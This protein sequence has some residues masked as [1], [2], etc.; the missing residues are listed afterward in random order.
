MNM[1]RN[2][3]RL[4]IPPKFENDEEKTRL[5]G[6][7]NSILLFVIVS[8]IIAV[9]LLAF[10]TDAANRL[11][12]ILFT[13]P[14]IVINVVSYLLLRRGNVPLASSLFLLSTGIGI[15][16][17]YVFSEPQSVAAWL[18]FSLLI[19]F[20]ALLLDFRA[21]IRLVVTIIIL[22][23]IISIAQMRGWITP[24]LIADTNPLS[25]W[26]TSSFIFILTGLGLILSSIRLRQAL[27]TARA[28]QE[29][30]QASNQDLDNLRQAL[31]LR[32]RERSAELEKRAAQLQTV[33]TVARTIAAVQDLELLLPEIARLVSDQFGFYHVGIFLLDDA[34]E[35]AVLRAANSEGGARMLDRHHKLKLD[36]NS[37]VGFATSRGVPRVALDVGADAVYLNNP[38]LPDT[39]SEMALPLRVGGRVIGALDVQSTQTNAFS[40]E[41]IG[42]LATLADQV[43]IAIEN[44]R[45]FGEARK[46]LAESQATFEKYVKQEWSSFARQS[47]QTGFVFDGKQVLPLDGDG[48]RQARTLPQTGS[49][50]WEKTSSTISVPIRLRGQTIGVLDVRPKSGQREWT[51]NEIALLEAAAERAAL[52]L[53]NAR[54]VES[55]QRRAA[56][57]RSISNIAAKIGAVSDIDL[58]LQTTVEELG[59][60]IG[61]TTEVILELEGEVI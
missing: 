11:P 42:V 13:A 16:G 2:F 35:F 31:E 34:N 3:R 28:S 22:T 46:A 51:Q 19:V 23:F 4:L 6:L 48:K 38:D 47:R 14:F 45:L 58:I 40:Q 61:G 37:I 43:A 26:F 36:M 59:R 32:V 24:L 27:D 55:A 49:L 57:E 12:L 25:N 8:T 30:L 20:T 15:I 44:A 52:A 10:S 7:L 53:E 41:D 18:S 50:S 9:P 54:L 17:A 29:R 39:R 21:I 1:R 5:A 56:R 33:S 60:R